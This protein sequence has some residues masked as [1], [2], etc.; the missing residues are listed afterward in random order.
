MGYLKLHFFISSFLII[1]LTVAQHPNFV[2]EICIP[3][4]GNYTNNSSY[5]ASLDS[6]LSSFSNT[7]VD[8]GFYNSSAGEVKAIALCRGDLTPDTC[9]SCVNTSS[10]EIRRLCPNYEEAI[11]HYDTC[12]LRYSNRSIFSEGEYFPLAIGINP[13]N[14]SDME[15]AIPALQKLLRDLKYEAASGGPLR[16]YATGE[17]MLESETIYAL[18]QCTP[19]L[20]NNQCTDCLDTINESVPTTLAE[21]K[22]GLRALGPSCHFRYETYSFYQ[23]PPDAPSPSPSPSPSPTVNLPHPPPSIGTTGNGMNSTSML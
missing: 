17:A 13:K 18:V 19:N 3:E 14:F 15:Q 4:G 6:L 1:H 8:Y 5:K 2:T 12:M 16:K 10:H 7:T 11:I 21:G 22:C 23:P 20:E 9:R